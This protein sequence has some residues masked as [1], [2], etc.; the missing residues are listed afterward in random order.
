MFTKQLLPKL[1]LKS[2]V[3]AGRKNKVKDK[4]SGNHIFGDSERCFDASV[5]EPFLEYLRLFYVYLGIR[6]HIKF[7]LFVD[8]K[9]LIGFI[10]DRF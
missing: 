4:K 5:F 3:I 1:K 2:A 7:S 9:L 6:G 10:P 8:F